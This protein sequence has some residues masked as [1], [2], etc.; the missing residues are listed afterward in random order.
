MSKSSD[1]LP[2][3]RQLADLY[4]VSEYAI[5]TAK[6]KG[7]DIHN[8][9][10]VRAHFLKGRKRPAA[11]VSGCPWD[12]VKMVD[13]VPERA[14][15]Y[16]IDMIQQVK[17]AIDYDEARTLKTK[18]DSLH[19]LRQIQIQDRDYIHKDEVTDDMTRIGNGLKAGLLRLQADLPPMLEGLGANEM[20]KVLQAK[21]YEMLGQWSNESSDLYKAEVV[22]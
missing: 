7:V 18:I 20:Q 9:D 3:Q 15:S 11:W 8:R 16:E 4:E 19:K 21:I 17:D 12:E 14:S 13:D 22:R 2:S 10:E 5:R 6:K 1:K